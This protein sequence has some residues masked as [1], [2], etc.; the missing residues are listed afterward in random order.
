MGGRSDRLGVRLQARPQLARP[1]HLGIAQREALHCYIFM[2]PSVLGLL[3]FSLGP[4]IASLLLSFTQYDVVSPPKWIGLQN[5]QDLLHDDLFW[6]ALKVT[7]LYSAVSVPATLA[8]GLLLALL[9]NQRFRGVYFLRTVY[10]LPTVISGVAVAMLWRWMFNADYGIINV[11]LG[12]VGVQGPQWLLSERWA[13]P[14]LIITSLW[15]FGGTMLI[16]LAGLQG[17]PT[18]LYEAAE[19]DGAGTWGKFRH[20]TLPLISHVTFFNLV[21]GIIGSLQVFAEAYVLTGGGPNNA[22]LLLSVYLYNN[23]FQYLKM[24]YASAIAW[25]MF[26]IVLLLTLLVLRSSSRWVFYEVEE[27]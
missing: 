14:A 24:G 26:V 15:G 7:S 25:V 20:V 6:Q 1:W 13:L 10:Y 2:A 23:A 4:M 17:I 8:L 27:S 16:Y 9:L 18:E 21:L 5:Y 12:K 3:L 22:T 19:I 11:L